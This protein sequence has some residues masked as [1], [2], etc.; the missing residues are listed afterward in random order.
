MANG[1]DEGACSEVLDWGRNVP[2]YVSDRG[3]SW[4]VSEFA[5]PQVEHCTRISGFQMAGMVQ[6]RP[7]I[8]QKELLHRQD[9]RCVLLQLIL[10]S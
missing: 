10:R 5:P 9:P 1:V 3:G 6:I 7:Q 2:Q 4:L 8:P